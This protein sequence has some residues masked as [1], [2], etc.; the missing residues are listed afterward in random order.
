MSTLT[1][2]AG[3]VKHINGAKLFRYLVSVD[4][5]PKECISRSY[6]QTIVSSVSRGYI[7]YLCDTN[8]SA[9]E[10]VVYPLVAHSNTTRNT[11]HLQ[12]I[13]GP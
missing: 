9:L 5:S 7:V 1:K 4:Q 10:T 3:H 11:V 2:M 8:F 12:P 6:L 13:S